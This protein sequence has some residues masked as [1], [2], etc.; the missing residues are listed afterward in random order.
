[1]GSEVKRYL[2]MAGSEVSEMVLASDYEAL[3]AEAKAL[4]DCTKRIDAYWQSEIRDCRN[5]RDALAVEC[6][7]LRE[8]LAKSSAAMKAAH[9]SMFTQCLSNPVLNTWGQP[10]NMS[11][12]NE[13][14]KA[15]SDADTALA[16]NTTKETR[17]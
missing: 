1:M 10:V 9:N 3:H 13:L 4:R 11:A 16:A 7:G 6:E 15:A 17:S 12:I 5:E 14:Q 2:V 8:A